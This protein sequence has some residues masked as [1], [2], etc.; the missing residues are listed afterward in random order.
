MT[1]YDI[2]IM[3][4]DNLGI[5]ILFLVVLMSLIE[6]SKI[7]INPWSCIGNIFNKD[8]RNKMDLQAKQISELSDK[9]TGVD[10]ELKEDKAMSARYRII[11]FDDE[12]RHGVIHTK[13]HYDQIIVDIDVYEKFCKLNPWFRNNQAHWAI[14]NIRK[15]YEEHNMDN[16][17]L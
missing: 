15:R 4:R 13:E 6:V 5:G 14:S 8:I 17:F 10:N 3:V 11:R 1:L 7:K 9:V 16:S 2:Y 12:I